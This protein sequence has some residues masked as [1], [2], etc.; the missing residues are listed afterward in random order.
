MK[1]RTFIAG[2]GAAAALPFAA[3]AQQGVPVVGFLHAGSA[4][5]NAHLVAAF[6]RGLEQVGFKEGRNVSVEYR[7]A[8]GKY[9]SLAQLAN[10][11]A[12]RHVAVFYTGGGAGAAIEARKASSSIPLVFVM[13]SDPVKAGL[14][15]SLARPGGDSTGVTLL[16]NGLEAKRLELLRQL[17]PSADS[18]AALI[19]QD[20]VNAPVVID[21]LQSASKALGIAVQLLQ[22]TTEA[23]LDAALAT[24][25][26]LKVGGVLVG[27]DPFFV[28]R[29]ER[30]IARI[31]GIGLPA[32]Y[33]SREFPAAGGLVSYG[34]NLADMYRKSGVYVGRVLKG[35]KPSDL[36]VQQPTTF[37]LIF[38]LKTA[39]ALGLTITPSLIATAD[40]VIE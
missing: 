13:G 30:I 31:A 22:A 23:Q 27:N 6:L 26:Q 39:K 36:P 1:R 18:I 25:P 16:T 5:P 4:Q 38:N 24:L 9:D 29:R 33:Q 28:S 7:W 32:V 2:V 35:E 3:W 12:D 20:N 8:E 37:E 40:E 14:V 21:E 10:D 17:V 15:A 19:N 34:S 11:L